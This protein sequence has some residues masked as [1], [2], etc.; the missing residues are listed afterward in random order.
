MAECGPSHDALHPATPPRRLLL[1]YWGRRGGGARYTLELAR[2][3]AARG[4]VD[5]HLSIS[6]QCELFEA[7]AEL[8]L[9]SYPVHTFQGKASAAWRSLTLPLLRQ[10]LRRYVWQ[11]QIDTVL[12]TMGH[13]W[14]SGI[15]G[16]LPSS[17]T[18]YVYTVHDGAPHPGEDGH[19]AQWLWR[20]HL[21][22]A[23][24][25]IVLSE[26]VRQ[27][28]IAYGIPPPHIAV[29]PH[30]ILGTDT[31]QSADANTR[32]ARRLSRPQAARLLFFGRIL[33]YKGLGLLLEAFQLLLPTY[34]DLQLEIVGE[35]DLTPYQTAI[36][37]LPHL[38]LRQGWL[39]EADIPAIF[40]RNDLCIL[41]YL[42]ASQSGVLALAYGS[43]MP[44]IVTPVGGLREQVRHGMSGIVTDAVSPN[45]LAQ[46]IRQ[47]LEQP[48][49]YAALSQGAL[50]LAQTELSWE[51][52]AKTLLEAL[53]APSFTTQT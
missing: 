13:V 12:C 19:I 38:S 39:P 17:H 50:T 53:Y 15:A 16:A 33:P 43:G 37:N 35:G 10:G 30:G 5:V 25:Y 4:D 9:P 52:I 1:W 2:A 18:R 26:A 31:G 44:V 8:K 11:Q 51:G 28:L 6:R 14:N 47:L 21:K 22:H 27:Q 46:S 48:D 42:E 23:S 20:R 45:A 7:F 29:V 36:N 49:R 24:A 32:A 3:L 41:P 34:P 40:A